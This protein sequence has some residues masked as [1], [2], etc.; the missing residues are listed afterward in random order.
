MLNIAWATL[1]SALVL[2]LPARSTPRAVR[3]HNLWDREVP[4]SE[5]LAWQRAL[6]ADRVAAKRKAA[7]DAG[8]QD[9]LLLMQH[10]PVLTLGTGSTLD[11]VKSREDPPFELI[12]T[13]RGGEVT[14]HGPGQLVMYP[15]LDLSIY[16][17][18]V[19]WYLRALEEVAMRTCRSLGLEAER[20]SGLTG[21]W[22]RGGKTCARGVKLSRWVS[23]HGLAL[24]VCPDLQHFDSIVPCGISDRPVTSIAAELGTAAHERGQLLE[25][26]QSLLLHHFSAVFAVELCHVHEHDDE[27]EGVLV[28]EDTRGVSSSRTRQGL[29]SFE[30]LDSHHGEEEGT[31]RR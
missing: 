1:V 31:A 18:D 3:V 10:P 9:T 8:L 28:G 26:A 24:N 25:E 14:Y 22:V 21:V 7:D 27:E 15:V 17:A 2:E 19:N 23:M 20:E 16:R 11:N 29:S 30:E 4:F 5:A 13:E 12:R 6:Q